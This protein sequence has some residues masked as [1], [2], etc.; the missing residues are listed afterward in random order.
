MILDSFKTKKSKE[1]KISIVSVFNIIIL[2]IGTNIILTS[3][4]ILFKGEFIKLNSKDKIEINLK[5]I[6]DN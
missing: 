3:S 1:F 6:I 4:F 5:T 2:I